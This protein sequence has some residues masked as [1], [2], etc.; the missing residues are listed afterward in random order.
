MNLVDIPPGEQMPEHQETEH[1]QEEVFYVVSGRPTLVVDG[2]VARR[3]PARSRASIP[4]TAGP[5][6][7][8]GDGPATVL[9]ASA[10]RTSGYQPTEWA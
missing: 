4:S 3:S 9:I 8:D 1:G 2:E 7:N 10:P 5:I 6:R